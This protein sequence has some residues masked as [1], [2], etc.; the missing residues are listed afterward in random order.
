MKIR[1]SLSKLLQSWQVQLAPN[2]N[3]MAAVWERIRRLKQRNR[4]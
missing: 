1:K 3:F 4:R 2:P